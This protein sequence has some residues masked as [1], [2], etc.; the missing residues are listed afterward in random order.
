MP[1]E[2]KKLEENKKTVAGFYQKA[3]FGY[4][5]SH[6]DSRSGWI[7]HFL[8]CRVLAS[9]R[10][11]RFIPALSELPAIRAQSQAGKADYIPTGR[12]HITGSD[13]TLMPHENCKHS[14]Q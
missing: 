4:A 13:Q 14:V 10:T 9:P 12:L 11:C 6:Q 2:N 1:A 3:L 7:R 5:P 8:S